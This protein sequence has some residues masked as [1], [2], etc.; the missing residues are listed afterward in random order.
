MARLLGL[1]IAANRSPR[2][3]HILDY[4]NLELIENLNS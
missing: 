1:P 2:L 4:Q 3:A